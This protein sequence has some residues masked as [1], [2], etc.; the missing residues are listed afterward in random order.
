MPGQLPG[1][2]LLASLAQYPFADADDLSRLLQRRDE[3]QWRD[4]AFAMAPPQQRF[5]PGHQRC[6]LVQAIDRL[7]VQFEFILLQCLA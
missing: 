7:V 2:G 3:L 6:P 4:Q 1:S 5:D